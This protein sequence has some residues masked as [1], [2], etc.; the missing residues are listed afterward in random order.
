[1]ERERGNWEERR[2]L[3]KESEGEGRENGRRKLSA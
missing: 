2:A 3:R 1:M